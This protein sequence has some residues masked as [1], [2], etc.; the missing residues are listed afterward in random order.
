MITR[1]HTLTTN[2]DGGTAFS[3][4]DGILTIQAEY[5]DVNGDFDIIPVQTNES[6]NK[7]YRPVLDENGNPI[8]GRV[9]KH[10]SAKKTFSGGITVNVVDLR[11]IDAKVLIKRIGADPADAGT[12]NLYIKNT[13]TET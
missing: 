5:S 12:V 6:S 10:N 9:R 2:Y 11:C 4:D 3:V 7:T 13:E 8:V 1:T